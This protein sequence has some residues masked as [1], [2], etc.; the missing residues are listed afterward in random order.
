MKFPAHVKYEEPLFVYPAFLY[1]ENVYLLNEEL[2]HYYLREG[3]IVTSEIGKRILDHPNV[4]L[5]LLE[6][7][8]GR[9]DL[10]A[11]YKDI[12]EIYFLWSFFCETINFAGAHS[13]SFIPLEY[14]KNMQHVCKTFFPAWA[15]NPYLYMIPEGGIE[16]LKSIDEDFE[17]QSQL[18]AFIIKVKD[19]I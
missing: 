10:F 3:S 4:Q 6:Y 11:E 13:D 18:N 7:C 12:F 9:P 16:I 1:A 17:T 19:F 5:M 15:Q 2:Y 14:F 8:L